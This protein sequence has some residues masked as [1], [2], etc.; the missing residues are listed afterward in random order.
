MAAQWRNIQQTGFVHPYPHCLAVP[1][2]MPEL[3]QQG[4]ASCGYRS[5]GYDFW[6]L[7]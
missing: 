5:C 7:K 2:S 1:Q 3:G 4:Y 6:A